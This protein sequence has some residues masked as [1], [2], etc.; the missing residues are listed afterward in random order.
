MAGLNLKAETKCGF[1]VDEKR[2]KI[3]QKELEILEEIIR[4]CDKYNIRY[5][6]AG[7]TALGTVRHS[8][9]IPWDDDIDIIMKR[10]DYNNFIQ[11][12]L[13]ELKEPLFLQYNKTEK[14]YFRGHIQV[15]NSN[16][17]AIIKGDICNNYNKGIFVDIFPLDNVP[18]DEKE[19]KIF[20]KKMTIKK[21]I[22]ASSEYISGNSKIKNII[23]KIV[24]KNLYWKI[25]NIDKEIEKFNVLANKYNDINTK[26][27]GAIT[28]N[29]NEFKYENAWLEDIIK[30]DFEYL[31]INISRHYDEI[32]TREYGNYMK[33]PENKNGSIHGS[34]FFDTEKSYKEYE[35]NIKSI[36]EKL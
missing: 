7:G 28:F 3:W 4:I 12:A 18:D 36:V 15:R 11:V 30:M 32:L 23:K 6:A 2:K 20:L 14:G 1:Y 35:K 9:F 5:L 22:L 34:V 31:K 10:D 16:T 21:K 26:Q 17:T 24:F 25:F 29:P 13:K 19:R 8:G 27:C 33:L